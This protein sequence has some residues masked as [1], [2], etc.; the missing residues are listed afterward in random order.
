MIWTSS[1]YCSN[2]KF[3]VSKFV[4]NSLQWCFLQ[5]F[6]KSFWEKEKMRAEKSC[7]EEKMFIRKKVDLVRKGLLVVVHSNIIKITLFTEYWVVLSIFVSVSSL[8]C[9]TDVSDFTKIVHPYILQDFLLPMVTDWPS[10]WFTCFLY[11]G[12]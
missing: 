5:G 9:L 11:Q 6:W 12:W 3:A 10:H 7:G 8:E 1:E 4:L 2:I